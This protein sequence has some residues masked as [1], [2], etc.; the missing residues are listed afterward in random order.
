V[1]ADQ[2]AIRRRERG[3]HLVDVTRRGHE[4]KRRRLLRD[5]ETE[6]VE[7]GV[8]VEGRGLRLALAAGN[9]TGGQAGRQPRGPEQKT[10]GCTCQRA[11]RD[12]LAN[13]VAAIVH[14]EVVAGDGPAHDQAVVPVVLDER[15][16]LQPRLPRRAL[17]YLR[18]SVL[19]PLDVRED[20]E[21]EV[22]RPG[23]T[24]SGHASEA[25]SKPPA[26]VCATAPDYGHRVRCDYQVACADVPDAARTRDSYGRSVDRR[27]T[28]LAE[29]RSRFLAGFAL[30][31]LT[32]GGL[33]KLGGAGD[34][35]DAVWTVAVVICS[36]ELL[37]EVLHTVL[38]ERRMGVDTVALIAMVGSLVLGQ[39]LAG[40]IVALMFSGGAAL[41]DWA[42][43]RAKRELTELIQRAPK[44]AQVR[45]G[46]G[47]DEVPIEQVQPGDIVLVRTGEVV[48]VD[49]KVVS[50][51]AVIDTSTLTGEPL[52][53]TL[54]PGM[55]VLS[56]SANAGV[57]FDVRA[58]KPA[59]DS[60]YAALVRL[61]EQSQAH[62][63]PFV[64]M[65]DRYAGWFVPATLLIAGAAWA[66]S[67]DAVRGLAVVVVAT[68]CPLIL[69][70]P[71][72]LVSGVA[73][74]AQSGVIVKG[75]PAI[76]ALGEARTV[77][78]DKTGTLTVGTPE[79][80][81]VIAVDGV[82][83]G[84]LL[85]LAASVDRFSA[86]VLG[87]ALV[88]AADESELKLSAPQNVHEDPGQ[89]IEGVVDGRSVGVGSRAF[90]TALGVPSEEVASAALAIGRGS[91]EAHVNVSLDGHVGGVIVMADE[92]RPDAREAVDRLRGEGI[93][94]VAMASGDRRSV[95]ERIGR[96]LGVDRVYAE[97]SPQDKLGIVR[98]LRE[99]PQLRTVVMVG[100]GV[101]DA[102]A[103]A[104]ADVGVAMG[105]A[106]A[107]VAAETADAVI[108]VDRI[109]R[110]ADA[111]HAGRR[112]L[113]IATQSVQIGMGLSI[114]AM[115]VA[116][117]G[118]L[119][120]VAGA[121]LQEVIDLAVIVNALR[122]RRG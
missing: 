114:A 25:D 68:P 35:G 20:H 105:A 104:L 122:A 21:R 60:A 90:V 27:M 19:G 73:R 65:A 4:R 46:D 24:R 62:R 87:E 61:V 79:V 116:A 57:P 100:D 117:F 111:I 58:S 112:S 67:G 89:G 71:I 33:L 48:P 18:V 118:Y 70:A 106:S 84:E 92:L 2:L 115:I 72:A 44:V 23:Y 120:P 28:W 109:G 43:M 88:R 10:D 45:R 40:M 95:A 37:V 13:D 97:Q 36:A 38:V 30:A 55:A 78:F 32:A 6:L 86:H 85:R 77:L 59:A 56:G 75:T 29:H 9:A 110:V 121:L 11:L 31:T 119:P 101:N 41:E 26:P 99:D 51:E 107:T 15:D 7:Q 82:P 17:A 53:E 76:E 47:V 93:R 50:A 42:A 5:L 69:A 3:D 63:A 81:E 12:A 8:V 113:H 54:G 39:E 83:S 52:P 1:V 94:H 91:G 34:A 64:R 74:A 98:R 14:V 80:R 66:L 96:E 49:G 102:P 22:Q 103:L 16:L 108:V